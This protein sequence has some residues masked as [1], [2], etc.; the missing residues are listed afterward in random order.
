[1]ETL[2]NIT[3][4]IIPVMLLFTGIVYAASTSELLQQGLP[5]AA[6]DPLHRRQLERWW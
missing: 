4:S 3:I 5:G 6:V 1:M 2:K